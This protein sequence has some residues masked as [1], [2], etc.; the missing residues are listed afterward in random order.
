MGDEAAAAAAKL[1]AVALKLPT[2]W[3]NQPSVW[4]A[5]AEAQFALLGITV[6]DTKYYHVVRALDQETATQLVDLLTA[7]PE[8]DKYKAIKTRLTETFGLSPREKASKLLHM[9]GLGDR[10]PSALMDEM[11]ALAGEH[12]SCL[13][14]EQIFLEQMPDDIR[15]ILC[16]QEFENPRQLAAQADKLWL[17]G[18]REASISAAAS[19]REDNAGAAVC[20][21]RPAKNVQSPEKLQE[22]KTGSM[23]NGWCYFHRRW[24]NNARRCRA[25]CS[26]PGNGLAGRQ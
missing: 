15:M 21:A 23:G 26:H 22:R 4:F 8:A 12:K 10:K 7:P 13:I 3:S 16:E 6:D 1:H 25:P 14:F 20:A 17:S 11:L 5:Q 19:A 2:F 18:R 9:D 24:G